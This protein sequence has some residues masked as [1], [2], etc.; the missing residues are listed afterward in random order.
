MIKCI[1]FSIL[2][3]GIFSASTFLISCDNDDNDDDNAETC[4]VC[5]STSCCNEINTENCCCL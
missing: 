3:M 5:G 4:N 2:I 1:K